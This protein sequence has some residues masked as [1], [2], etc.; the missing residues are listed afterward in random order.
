MSEGSVWPELLR[1]DSERVD[2]DWQECRRLLH[3]ASVTWSADFSRFRDMESP[4]SESKTFED[5]AK[6]VIK[7]KL[8]KRPD[9]ITDLARA[10]ADDDGAEL[11]AK[12][13]S[14]RHDATSSEGVE[15]P[16]ATT[17]KKTPGK[18][19][20]EKADKADKVEKV[21]KA[22]KIEN[23]LPKRRGFVSAKRSRVSAEDE[24]KTKKSGKESEPIP[25]LGGEDDLEGREPSEQVV[26]RPRR[27]KETRQAKGRGHRKENGVKEKLSTPATREATSSAEALTSLTAS[28]THDTEE[29]HEEADE[30]M[31]LE[32]SSPTRMSSLLSQTVED[33]V[34]VELRHE[35][36]KTVSFE[37]ATRRKD[38]TL[39]PTVLLASLGTGPPPAE[40]VEPAVPTA[41]ASTSLKVLIINK[42]TSHAL[43]TGWSPVADDTLPKAPEAV[44]ARRGIPIMY[45]KPKEIPQASIPDELYSLWMPKQE[46]ATEFDTLLSLWVGRLRR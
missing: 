22:R 44:V 2:E 4:R 35:S 25:S 19:T 27:A 5:T 21:E 17:V 15:S 6:V 37:E 38:L 43:V 10:K 40:P 7:K 45:E 20:A 29:L 16:D 32:S 11:I 23:V 39:S 33:D 34:P 28:V 13:T 12:S 1:L 8:P 9:H 18:D 30:E 41:P 26:T 36:K 24:E 46:A 14:R 31:S 3:Q 42:E